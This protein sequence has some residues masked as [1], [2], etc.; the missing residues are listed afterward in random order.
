MFV[1]EYVFTRSSVALSN[2]DIDCDYAILLAHEDLNFR[3][4]SPKFMCFTL[5]RSDQKMLI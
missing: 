4:L 2:K 1:Q 3:N 5:L